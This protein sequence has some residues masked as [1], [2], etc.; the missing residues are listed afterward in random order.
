MTILQRYTK[1]DFDTNYANGFWTAD[2]LLDVMAD[3]AASAPD[4]L[5]VVD[6]ERHVTRAELAGLVE[7]A[8]AAFHR[9]GMGRDDVVAVQLPNSVHAVVVALALFR[10]GAVFH[11]VNP[12]Y[13]HADI[14]K[15]FNRSRPRFYIHTRR[16]RAFDYAPL[17][18]SLRSDG[19]FGFAAV[20]VDVD[21]PPE[22][23]F[24][25]GRLP[26]HVGRP[27]PDAVILIGATSGSTG[28]PKLFMHTHNTQFNEA[29]ELNRQ[30]GLGEDD[31]FLAFAPITHR[32][33]FMWGF[34]Q[35]MAAGAAFVLERLYDPEAVLRQ[36]DRYGVTSLFTI[37]TQA[38]DLLDAC[39][40]GVGTGRSLR[41][42]MLAGAPVQPGLVRR[43]R[44]TWPG[45]APVTGYGTSETGF[46]VVTLPHYPLEQLQTCGQPLP[47]MEV[48]VDRD[49]ASEDPNGELQLRGAYVSAGYY[50]DQKATSEAFAGDG[51]IRTG[52]IGHID[53]DGNVVVT[54]RLKNVIIRSGLKI[55]A[56]EVEEVLL[57]HDAI[58]HAVLIGI[59]D[60]QVGERS[61]ACLVLRGG[62]SI[63]LEELTG[64]LDR[65]GIAKFKWPEK[66][67]IFDA[68]PMNAIGKFD[69]I[70][71]RRQLNA[72]Q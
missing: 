2:H 18:D 41:V 4:R 14:V 44:E 60:D 25:E 9:A 69:R 27:D 51:W 55:Q 34:M 8:A 67:V 72:G 52:D 40:R 49:P 38:V 36:I 5:A 50:G 63:T 3:H 15:I 47:G 65:Q 21:R 54:G 19:R 12:S 71:M 48:R 17:V 10:V 28:D 57:R 35:S 32:G 23:V 33:V 7:R 24:P 58:A 53:G 45:C 16:F 42:F 46:A 66:L 39:D 70:V 37:P 62:R 30:M 59:S 22:E 6:G 56:E 1:R 20:E 64:F 29:R 26:D 13:R 43:L 11:G 31:V 68:L 61:A